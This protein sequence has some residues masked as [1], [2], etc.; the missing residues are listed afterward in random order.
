MLDFAI[1]AN[2]LRGKS[3][4]KTDNNNRASLIREVANSFFSE[5]SETPIPLSNQVNA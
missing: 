1:A 5:N 3:E 4:D 2:V